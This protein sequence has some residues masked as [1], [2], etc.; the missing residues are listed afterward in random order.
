MAV[1]VFGLL[2]AGIVGTEVRVAD[3]RQAVSFE[4]LGDSLFVQWAVPFEVA[5]LV[6]LVALIGAIVLVRS[7][8]GRE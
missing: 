5:S 1:A 2:V 8:G 3:S 4:A 6:L 7:T